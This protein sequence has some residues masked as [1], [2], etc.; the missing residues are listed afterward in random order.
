MDRYEKG[1]R[2]FAQ[3][4]LDL[5]LEKEFDYKI[6]QRLIPKMKPGMRIWVPFG[7][8]RLPGYITRIKEHTAFPKVKEI[9]NLID[10]ESLISEG[11]IELAEWISEYYCCNLGK[12]F[13]A[14]LPSKIR[15]IAP[16]K[17]EMKYVKL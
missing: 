12:V 13:K 5:P 7:N 9:I 16:R 3:V 2:M 4:V 1:E 15:Q 6:P 11:L 10:Q 14:M 17:D 8:R